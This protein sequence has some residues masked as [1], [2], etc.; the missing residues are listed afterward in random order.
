MT[1]KYYHNI[2]QRSDEWHSLRLGIITASEMNKVLTPTLK[3]ANNKETRSHFYDL[4][5][6]RITQYT[7]D[8]YVSY[9]MEQGMLLE[10][11][12]RIAYDHHHAPVKECG[13]VTNDELGFTIGF[14]PD[15]LVGDDGFIETKCRMAKFQVQTIL[16]H[17]NEQEPDTPI[18]G[19][20]M[21]QCQ[22]GLF[23]TQRKWC[24]FNSFSNGLNMATIRVF[25]DVEYQSAIKAAAI[26][27]EAKIVQLVSQYNMTLAANPDNIH[28]VERVDYSEEISV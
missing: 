17:M 12:A 27:A 20:F 11:D 23:V 26:S 13:F 2:K 16:E 9:Q 7:E 1:V 14:S 28:A 10:S 3:T 15:G 22:T 5:A 18:P 6:Q 25:P 21:L 8:H 24:D 4:A 19:E